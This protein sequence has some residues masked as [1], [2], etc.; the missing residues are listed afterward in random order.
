MA[1]P[2]QGARHDDGRLGFD[3]RDAAL[4]LLKEHSPDLLVTEV[5]LPE[6]SDRALSL[7]TSG[8]CLDPNL[9]AIVV[10]GRDDAALRNAAFVAGASAYVLK[11]AE[12]EAVKTAISEAVEPT[13]YLARWRER[14][15]RGS[16]GGRPPV[17][18]R[19]TRRE[20]EILQLVSEGG[21]NRQVGQSALD[22]RPDGEVP[23]RERLP[24][25]RRRESLRRGSLG[26][27]ARRLLDGESGEVVTIGGGQRC[28]TGTRPAHASFQSPSDP[29]GLDAGARYRRWADGEHPDDPECKG[30]LAAPS[31]A[32]ATV[33]R[34]AGRRS[35]RQS[36]FFTA[37]APSRSSLPVSSESVQLRAKGVTSCMSRRPLPT[38]SGMR[39]PSR[40]VPASSRAARAYSWPGAAAFA[41][42]ARRGRGRDRRRK[43]PS[44]WKR[45]RRRRGPRSHPRPGGARDQRVGH[46]SLGERGVLGE[47]E[48]RDAR[49]YRGREGGAADLPPGSDRRVHDDLAAGG[50]QRHPGPAGRPEVER[51]DCRR[52]APTEARLDTPLGTAE[53]VVPTFPA[54]PSTST[55][56]AI[57]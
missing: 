15:D 34:P 16:G 53:G 8:R 26:A 41:G 1:A 18:P 9:R 56:R 37:G 17:A 35:D 20:L 12:L 43:S 44:L 4:A 46:L 10:S 52:V 23:P 49:H 2:S 57:A 36:R 55:P 28:M 14:P 42:A 5:A 3:V 39:V 13:I 11:T 24:Q 25:A 33:Y 27:R 6:G 45:R 40:N 51:V 50:G 19:L 21:S 54:D 47:D 30:R 31:Q 38:R 48:P 32:I 29:Q 7:I 22:H